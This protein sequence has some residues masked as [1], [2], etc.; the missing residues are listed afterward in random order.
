MK[1]SATQ[2]HGYHPSSHKKSINKSLSYIYKGVVYETVRNM[3]CETL[4]SCPPIAFVD[5]Q[6]SCSFLWSS[7]WSQRFRVILLSG[8]YCSFMKL[9]SPP[10]NS[11]DLQ[12]PGESETAHMLKMFSFGEFGEEPK[13]KTVSLRWIG[14]WVLLR[15]LCYCV[16]MGQWH[17]TS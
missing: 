12:C 1:S 13:N 7:T 17:D 10:N 3:M 14:I 2:S 6:C 4:K 15:T 11:W 16:E 9:C 8:L 5:V